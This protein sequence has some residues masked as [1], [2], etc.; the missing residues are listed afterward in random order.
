MSIQP[1]PADV[2]AFTEETDK[3]PG[4]EAGDQGLEMRGWGA[5]ASGQKT[6]VG[7]QKS[8]CQA[9]AV[10]T[11]SLALSG[12]SLPNLLLNDDLARRRKLL[13]KSMSA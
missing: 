6:G 5:G 3:R 13:I 12:I 9:I 11:P 8:R 1:L 7:N 2:R 4:P 10:S